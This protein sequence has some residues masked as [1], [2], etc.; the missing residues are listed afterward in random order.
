MD[1]TTYLTGM[2]PLVMLVS[3]SLTA[4]TSAVLLWLYRR[5]TLRGMA[6]ASGAAELP[7]EPSGREEAATASGSPLTIKSWQGGTVSPT[8]AAAETEY[9]RTAH[10]LWTAAGV[11]AAGGL[12]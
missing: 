7:S 5:A 2:L 8:L 12:V 6:Q 11:Y 4:V 1:L 3:A 10:S 9:R